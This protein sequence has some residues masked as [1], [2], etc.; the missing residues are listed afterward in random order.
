MIT[1][2][3]LD[4]RVKVNGKSTKGWR[5]GKACAVSETPLYLQNTGHARSIIIC[6]DE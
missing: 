5:A 3:E 4:E 1:E 6:F 2:K